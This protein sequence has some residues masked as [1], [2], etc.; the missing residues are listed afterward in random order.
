[1]AKIK[2]NVHLQDPD[3]RRVILSKGDEI[4]EWA[5]VHEALIERPNPPRKKAPAK[6][7]APKRVTAKPNPGVDTPTLESD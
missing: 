2:A 5:V 1:M 7:Q 4:P 3:G 6:K